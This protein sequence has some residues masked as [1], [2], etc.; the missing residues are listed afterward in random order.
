MKQKYKQLKQR[1]Q[2]DFKTGKLSDA[3]SVF[4]LLLPYA[5]L[6]SLFI[7]IP[8]AIAVGLSLTSFNLIEAPEYRGLMNYITVLTKD[9]VFLKYVLPNTFKYAL[10]TGPGGYMLAFIL[11]WM[12]AQI[13]RIPR[14]IIALAIY[15][16]SMLGPILMQVIF[17]VLF[18]GDENGWLNSVLLSNDFISKPIQFLQ[19]PAWLMDIMIIVSLYS[20]M[21]IGFLAMLAGVLNGNEELYEA[22]YIDGIKNKF[23]EVIHI[24]IPSMKPQMLFGAVMAIVQSFNNGYIGVALSGQ[25]PTPQYSGQLII[26]HI[27]DFGMIRYEMGYAAALSVVLLLIIWG[28]SKTAYILFGEKD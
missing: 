1:V 4:F 28:F 18:N 21:G 11:A 7:A 9:P 26:N 22:A 16:P 17:R 8:V 25:N 13:Q 2:H 15:T 27:E 24:T 3:L 5:L 19:D 6:F 14:T 20:A 23:Q 12:L 10:I